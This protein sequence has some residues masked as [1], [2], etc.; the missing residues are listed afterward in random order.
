MS[1]IPFMRSAWEAEA[2]EA[3]CL[4]AGASLVLGIAGV[5]DPPRYSHPVVNITIDGLPDEFQPPVLARRIPM[6][7]GAPAAQVD[8]IFPN[9]GSPRRGM[10]QVYLEGRGF[11]HAVAF[12]I[13]QIEALARVE[14]WIE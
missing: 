2:D 12:G 4:A 10:I 11:A 14:G 5:I 9:H 6:L 7:N 3:L 1:G 8:M 13:E